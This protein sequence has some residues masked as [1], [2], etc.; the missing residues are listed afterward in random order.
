MNDARSRRRLFALGRVVSTPG[1]L[2]ALIGEG[3]TPFDYLNRH[4][5]G[6]WSEMDPE[7]QRANQQACR[8]E[9]DPEMRSRVFSAYTT[10]AGTKIWVITEH[11]RSAT[12][13]L[14][15]SEY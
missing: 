13:I 2:A 1:A 10:K 6:D 14:L 12:T 4:Q 7:D 15:P 9:D 8:H 11:D 5:T 3:E